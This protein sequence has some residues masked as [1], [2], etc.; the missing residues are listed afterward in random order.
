MSVRTITTS[1]AFVSHR[2]WAPCIAGLAY[3]ALAAAMIHLTTSGGSIA[4]VWPANA[5]LLAV[6]LH[7]PRSQWWSVLLA[8]FIGNA[9]ANVITRG[10]LWAPILFGTANMVE[11]IV[12]ALAL[13]GIVKNS[14]LLN[15]PSALVRFLLWAGLIAPAAGGLFGASA[16]WLLFN[17]PFG[18]SFA[19]WVLADSLGLLIFTPFLFTLFAGDY[20]R[21]FKGRKKSQRLEAV[22]LLTLTALVTIFTF[23]RHYPVL[24][25]LFMPVMLVTFRLDWLGTKL[26]V[27]IV[28]VIGTIMIMSG[29]GPIPLLFES[30]A[31]QALGFQLFLAALLLLAYPIAAT[32]AARRKLMQELGESERSLRLLASQSPIV[33]LNF[34]LAGVCQKALG[35]SEMLLG[36]RPDSLI[37]HSFADMSEEGNLELRSAH[38]RAIDEPYSIQSVEFRAF[39]VNGKWLEATFRMSADEQGRCLGTLATV[40]DITER[41]QQELMLAR[42]AS[43]DSLTGLLNRAG[44]LARLEKALGDTRGGAMSLAMIDVDRF[45]LINDNAGHQAG[46]VVLKEIAARISAE[47]RSSDAVGRLGGDEF[48][49]LLATQDWN[50]AQEIC[51]RVVE[52]VSA[53]A[54]TLP[55]SGAIRTAI[56]CGVAQYRQGLSAEEFIHEADIAL[57]EAKRAGRNRVVAAWA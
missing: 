9:V 8:A 49:I 48:I 13:M 14:G 1:T 22:A 25:L 6:M 46:D 31:Y 26:A 30:R 56:S 41:K 53:E 43:T 52:A 36:R 50:K 19:T 38:E 7:R 11:V 21:C 2:F 37:G 55:A 12:A 33:L 47:V 45:K 5:V 20:A 10:T 35:A 34:D 17:Q 16:A 4:T 42:S 28:A 32:L 15:N 40:H 57:Y 24:F 51:R 3:F 18:M 29:S 27:M 39:R 54:I 23:T 44:F